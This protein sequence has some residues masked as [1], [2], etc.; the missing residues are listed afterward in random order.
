MEDH[1]TIEKKIDALHNELQDIKKIMIGNPLI[2]GDG[3]IIAD[4]NEHNKR[5]AKLERVKNFAIAFLLA[6][7]TLGGWKITELFDKLPIH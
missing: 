1:R 2:S 7:A 6:M 5:I 4:I 3:G